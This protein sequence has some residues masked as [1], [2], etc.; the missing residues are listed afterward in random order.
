M[1]SCGTACEGNL[2]TIKLYVQSDE[3]IMT[4]CSSCDRRSW[5]RGGRP[6]ELRTLLAD[7]AAQRAALRRAS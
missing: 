7:I 2:V 4:S 3:V 6:V 1:T 5:R